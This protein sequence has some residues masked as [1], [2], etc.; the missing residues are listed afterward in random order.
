[1]IRALRIIRVGALKIGADDVTGYCSYTD[2]FGSNNSDFDED[3]DDDDDDNDDD[4]GGHD[5]S[6]TS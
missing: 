6:L 2:S 1:M 4:S 5:G 3:F